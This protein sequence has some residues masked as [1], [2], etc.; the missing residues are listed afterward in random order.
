[1]VYSL[2]IERERVREREKERERERET[3]SFR[4]AGV[5]GFIGRWGGVSDLNLKS[6]SK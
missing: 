4:Q 2:Y 6:D 3:P 1:M 5:Q